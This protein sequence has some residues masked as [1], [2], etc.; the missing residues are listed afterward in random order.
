M[1]RRFWILKK[2]LRHKSKWNSYFRPGRCIVNLVLFFGHLAVNTNRYLRPLVCK[3]VGFNV[4][5][6]D[7]PWHR[8]S[9]RDEDYGRRL[10]G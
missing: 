10:Y 5:I 4:G 7:T 3:G 8:Q 1:A 2:A 6:Q 9:I